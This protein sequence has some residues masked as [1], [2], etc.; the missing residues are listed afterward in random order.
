MKLRWL[1][2]PAL[3]LL[4]MFVAAC[5]GS[6]TMRGTARR[7]ADHGRCRELPGGDSAARRRDDGRGRTAAAPSRHRRRRGDGGPAETTA[8]ETTAR[9]PRRP[10]RRAAASMGLMESDINT[11][12]GTDYYAYAWMVDFI[13]CNTLVGYPTT[14]DRLKNLELRP[15]LAAAMPEVSEDGLTYTFH[16]ARGRE[17]QRRPPRDAARTSRARS[18]A[19]LDP[20][21]R[22]PGLR[23]RL[24]RR[25][26]GRAR[27]QGRQGQGHRG[28]RGRRQHRHLHP[29]AEE[30]RLPQRAGARLRLHR[31]GRRAAPEDEPAAAR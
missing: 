2:L 30:R 8:E 12:D 23:H 22:V 27:V 3:L 10:C 14:T 13:T 24:L 31:A 15:E 7:H 4:T 18:C 20:E 19:P 5:G 16:A 28:H 26:Q 6:E 17:V 21:G 25:H 9:R 1:A 29:D 11:W